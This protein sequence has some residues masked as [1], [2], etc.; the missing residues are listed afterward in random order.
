MEET[1]GQ[2]EK[3]LTIGDIALMGVM[4]AVIEVCKVALNFL[5]NIELTSFWIIM[6]TLLFR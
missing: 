5:P 3:K 1:K 2:G 6:F 4:V